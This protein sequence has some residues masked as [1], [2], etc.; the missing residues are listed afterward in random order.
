MPAYVLSAK[1]WT[2]VI[3]GVLAIIF[4]LLAFV[5][6]GI[7]LLGLILLFGAYSI[8]D[9][10][11]DIAGAFQR[12][13][14]NNRWWVLLLEG[15]VSIAAGVIAF[16]YPGLTAIALVFVI[17]AWALV[18][19][20]LEIAAAIRL[21]RQIHGEWMLVLAG[22]LSIL[23]AILLVARP[24]VGA[25]AL[26]WWI[27]AYAIAWGALLIAL[28]FRLRSWARGEHPAGFGTVVPGH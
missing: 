21:R 1:W 17:A 12:D 9:G 26:V 2:F 6:P 3:R 15:V 20:A 22:V 16:V 13:S 4:G 28:G 5:L 14:Q 11:F 10:I 18:T 19:G 25:L 24:G 8:A 23:L 27:G 7:T